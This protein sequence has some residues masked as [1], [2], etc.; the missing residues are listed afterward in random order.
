LPDP[1]CL[2][3]FAT[4]VIPWSLLDSAKVPGGSAELRLLRRGTE[5]SIRLGTAELMNSRVC[6]SEQALANLA[7]R[8]IGGRAAP[9]FLI[10][11]LGMGFTLRAALAG[12][13]A[14]AR[15]TIAQRG[16]VIHGSWAE[17]DSAITAEIERARD[18]AASSAPRARMWLNEQANT[19]RGEE[20]DWLN[21]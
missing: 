11:G 1:F 14:Q 5:F 20:D 16:T 10:G 4:P 7:C 19:R 9:H 12:L 21:D 17:N 6:G 13:G 3:P 18:G 8:R 2:T 15:C